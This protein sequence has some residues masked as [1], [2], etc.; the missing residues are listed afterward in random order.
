MGSDTV[1]PVDGASKDDKDS[2]GQENF[3]QAQNRIKGGKP[4]GNSRGG[5][6]GGGGGGRQ[7]REPDE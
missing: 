6:G 2:R 7:L 5:R 1:I 4:Q 3:K